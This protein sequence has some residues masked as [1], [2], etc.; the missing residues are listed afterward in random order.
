MGGS[1]V[2]IILDALKNVSFAILTSYHLTLI[3]PT[4]TKQLILLIQL[5]SNFSL[6]VVH[7]VVSTFDRKICFAIQVRYNLS[8][9]FATFELHSN[10]SI[11]FIKIYIFYHLID[12]L[13]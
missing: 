11:Y 1:V 5:I 7:T 6:N 12:S 9:C 3:L 10:V 8:E 13:I 2:T 4:T